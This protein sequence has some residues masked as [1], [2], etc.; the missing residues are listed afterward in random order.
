[1]QS[2]SLAPVGDEKE[3]A[4]IAAARKTFLARGFDSASMDAIAL[5]AGVSKRT[6]YNRFRSKE[7]LFAAAIME[8]CRRVLPLEV[9]AAPG[10][11]PIE[12]SIRDMAITFLTGILEPEALA[13]RRIAAFEAARTPAL[14]KSYMDH[15]PRW[16]AKSTAPLLERIAANGPFKIDDVNEA[17]W[18]MGALI[19]EPLYTEVLMGEAPANL[20]EAIRRQVDRGLD[21]FF[22][23]YKK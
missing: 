7:E 6:V 15:G 13:L 18:R 8:T 19:T 23:I 12:E 17:V 3:A 10:D 20:E 5:A 16:M 21:A 4:I 11:A 9:D 1:M 2:P 22:Q 14:G